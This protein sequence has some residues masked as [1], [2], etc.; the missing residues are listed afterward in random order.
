MVF[1]QQNACQVQ[2]SDKV[3]V[4]GDGKLCLL[5]AHLLIVQRQTMLAIYLNGGIC[6]QVLQKSDK[7]AIIGDGKLGLL[8]AQ[9]LVVHGHTV[10]HFGKHEAKLRLVSGT[11]HE[12]VTE[13]TAERHAAVRGIMESIDARGQLIVGSTCQSVFTSSWM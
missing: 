7:V 1:P 12:L 11:Q 13:Q 5:V 3:A 6:C 9:M 10:T 4:D 8:V 2:K